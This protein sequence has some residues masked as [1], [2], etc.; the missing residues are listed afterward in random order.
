LDD[1]FGIV[2]PRDHLIGEAVNEHSMPFKKGLKGFV[3]AISGSADKGG[4]AQI[5]A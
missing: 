5:H 1:V 4:V 3:V 2:A